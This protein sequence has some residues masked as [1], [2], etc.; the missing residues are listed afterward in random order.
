MKRTK[1]RTVAIAATA[2]LTG[3]A[4]MTAGGPAS[5]APGWG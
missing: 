1:L 2:A 5:A 3:I 4:L